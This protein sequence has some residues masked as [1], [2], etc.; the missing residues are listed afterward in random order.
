MEPLTVAL[1][2]GLL[3]V[4]GFGML[5]GSCFTFLH[6]RQFLQNAEGVSGVVVENICKPGVG[7]GDRPAGCYCPRIRF[8]TVDGHE[9]N[10][11]SDSGCNPAAYSVGE[12]VSLLYDPQQPEKAS[13]NSLTSLWLLPFLLFILG[14]SA[15]VSLIIFLV[16]KIAGN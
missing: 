1:I 6:T 4:V 2:I 15:T 16:G 13:I 8:Q 12:S 11:V 5:V 3:F 10:F 9:I 14:M 7:M